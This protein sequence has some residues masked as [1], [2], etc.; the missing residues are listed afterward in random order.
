MATDK[1]KV[2]LAI[3]VG[4]TV[5]ALLTGVITVAPSRMRLRE[6]YHVGEAVGPEDTFM[7]ESDEFVG[8]DEAPFQAA[9]MSRR[10][11]LGGAAFVGQAAAGGLRPGRRIRVPGNNDVS[12]WRGSTTR[13]ARPSAPAPPAAAPR[14]PP[15]QTLGP[16][17]KAAA[18]EVAKTAAKILP[19]A[20][21]AAAKVTRA[22][23]KV[24][25]GAAR[26]ATAPKNAKRLGFMPEVTTNEGYTIIPR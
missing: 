2:F 23:V 26:A 24:A 7:G 4:L 18:A 16:K 13:F 20:A 17:A 22:A 15:A 14:A 10:G 6:S 8:E 11:A 5:A 12:Q 25:K 21:P 3:A 9:S 19:K 1:V